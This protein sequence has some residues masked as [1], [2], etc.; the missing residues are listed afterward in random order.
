MVAVNLGLAALLAL[1]S[2]PRNILAFAGNTA[3]L[4]AVGAI[5]FSNYFYD[6]S[7]AVF[8]TV[9]YWN[10][11]DRPLPLTLR[12]KA[13]LVDVVYFAEGLNSTIAVTQTDNYIS[14]RTNGKVDQPN[15]A[16]TT[17]L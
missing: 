6:P 2:A 17:Q 16:I 14:L 7:V 9:M 4:V 5:G 15:H 13:R 10:H 11:Y 3:L 8:N 12:E 1:V